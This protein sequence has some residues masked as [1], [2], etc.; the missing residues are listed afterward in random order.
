MGNGRPITVEFDEA[1]YERIALIAD[2][3]FGSIEAF[4]EEAVN[5]FLRRRTEEAVERFRPPEP[6]I[7]RKRVRVRAQRPKAR[8]ERKR[9]P[10]EDVERA[11][12]AILAKLDPAGPSHGSRSSR[13][14]QALCAV[15]RIHKALFRAAVR[16]LIRHGKVRITG[17]GR[18]AQYRLMATEGEEAFGKVVKAHVDLTL[19]AAG[20][21]KPVPPRAPSV[22][23]D[24]EDLQPEGVPSD[25]GTI[26]ADRI[27]IALERAGSIGATRAEIVR[28]AL[29]SL[30]GD[31]SVPSLFRAGMARLLRDGRAQK[32][33]TGTGAR[34]Y[35]V[36]G[37][38][39]G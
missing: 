39:E 35:A 17:R 26:A 24:L 23:L 38:K 19:A 4:V 36:A 33:G 31:G 1:T 13:A 12:G 7:T 3:Q 27:E 6:R 9:L 11:Y 21:D 32:S 20:N 10:V 25:P 15:D 37:K 30:E 16:L 2:A 34:Y 8:V 5:E 14:L 18:G 29:L 22:H 28:Q